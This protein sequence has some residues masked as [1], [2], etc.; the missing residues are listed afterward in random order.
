MGFTNI[1]E[2]TKSNAV[3][4]KDLEMGQSIEGYLSKFITTKGKYGETTSP[5]LVDKE[6]EETVVWAT[7]NLRYLPENF[8]KAGLQRGVMVRITKAALPSGTKFENYFDIEF[9][10]EDVIELPQDEANVDF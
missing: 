6:G 7:G 9:N 1:K 5:V 4:A 10:E 2:R 8:E 3:T